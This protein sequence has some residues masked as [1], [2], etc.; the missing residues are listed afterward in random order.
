MR[1]E[2]YNQVQQIYQANKVKKT[3]AGGTAPQ[4]D[5]LQLVR[6]GKEIRT[7]QASLSGVPDAREALT[8]PIKAK[9]RNG[10]YNVDTASFADRLLQKQAAKDAAYE[11]MR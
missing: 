10:T 7:A 11:E 4:T 8:A 3:S 9:I 5:Q 1:I 2:A 6:F